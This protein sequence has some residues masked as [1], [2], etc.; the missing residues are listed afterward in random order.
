MGRHHD[1]R[2]STGQADNFANEEPSDGRGV[3]SIS[4]L[5]DG[6]SP[7]RPARYA[8]DEERDATASREDED[9]VHPAY[10]AHESE[11]RP[12]PFQ[13]SP[14]NGARHDESA[15]LSEN[16]ASLARRPPSPK[17]PN[18]A[19]EIAETGPPTAVHA[20]A[21]KKGHPSKAA[22]VP[23]ESDSTA[24]GVSGSAAAKSTNGKVALKLRENPLPP[25]SRNVDLYAPPTASAKKSAKGASGWDSDLSA[26]ENQPQW[27]EELNR[28]T[29]ELNNRRVSIEL[30][31][32]AKEKVSAFYEFGDYSQN[33]PSLDVLG[34]IIS[35]STGTAPSGWRAPLPRL[36][37]SIF[38]S[39]A[40]R[41]SP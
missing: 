27:Q 33:E 30:A 24:T 25:S 36:W 17:A 16:G 4:H 15:A 41:S 19:A 29:V 20:P 31:L 9:H 28:F 38:C 6:G 39:H 37:E 34:F 18:D 11:P 5:L 8:Y 26:E 3:A 32:E 22:A 14:S 35:A 21:P 40:S 1:T 23:S 13:A 12:Q 10:T 2:S 7:R